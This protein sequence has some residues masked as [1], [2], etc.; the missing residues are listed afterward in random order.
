MSVVIPFRRF[1]RRTDVPPLLFVE[2]FEYQLDEP[3]PARTE[4]AVSALANCR[5]LLEHAR[6]QGWPVGFTI[7]LSR[8]RKLEGA[9][10]G[11]IEG[12]QPRRR[13]MVFETSGDSCYTSTEFAEAMTS[14]GN[15][16][17]LAGFSGERICLATFI[18]AARN[19]HRAGLIEDA[20]CVRQMH[21]LNATESHRALIAIASNH[22]TILTAREWLH[23]GGTTRPDLEP[24]YDRS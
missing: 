7:S 18:D 20:T 8:T 16:F 24:C 14:A 6:S 22:A 4:Q 17:L 2:M 11:W 10:L 23:Y 13:D 15:C 21:G 12:F 3:M 19:G 1:L 9:G 5:S